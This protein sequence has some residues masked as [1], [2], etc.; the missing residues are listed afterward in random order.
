MEGQNDAYKFTKFPRSWED[1]PSFKITAER[2]YKVAEVLVKEGAVIE[3]GTRVV[4][5]DILEEE[6]RPKSSTR[7]TQS[8]TSESLQS[9]DDDDNEVPAAPLPLS[10]TS[11]PPQQEAIPSPL[12]AQP[13]QSSSPL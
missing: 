2:H 3:A 7:S 12:Q 9:K 10:P 5:L 8:D 4:T 1:I 6:E 13:T 11:P